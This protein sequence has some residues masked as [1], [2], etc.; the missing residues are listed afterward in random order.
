MSDPIERFWFT[1][2][3]ITAL[4]REMKRAVLKHGVENTPLAC[5]DESNM[6]VL[7]EEIGEVAELESAD[8]HYIV[9]LTARL[10]RIARWQTYD[11]RDAGQLAAELLQCA[12]MSL[13]WYQQVKERL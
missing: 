11:N 7:A 8:P 13:A 5:T 1:P 3:S 12:A 9:E 6:K 2:E 10:G 4:Q